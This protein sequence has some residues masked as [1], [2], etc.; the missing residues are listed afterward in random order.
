MATVEQNDWV[1]RVL[2]V[3]VGA[4]GGPGSDRSTAGRVDG[5]FVALQKSRLAWDAA[6]KRVASEI[7][8]FKQ[9][10]RTALAGDPDEDEFIDALDDLDE[11]LDNLDERLIDTLD[12]LLA[13]SAESEAR[14]DLLDEARARVDAYQAYV[15]S[16][17]LVGRL[18]GPTVGGLN[19]TV[20][21]TIVSTLKVL[22]ANL[23]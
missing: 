20:G 7:E 10:V 6:R 12:D 15:D 19:L 11:I 5:N 17:P 13:E 23:H 22:R 8:A 2:G 14:K 4:A 9:E 21:P 18:A 1:A 16:E 3:A